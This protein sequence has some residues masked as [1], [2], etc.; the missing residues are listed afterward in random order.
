MSAAAAS[1]SRS[2]PNASSSIRACRAVST[3]I[4]GERHSERAGQFKASPRRVEARTERR[5][6]VYRLE[7]ELGGVRPPL[8]EGD[9]TARGG[10]RAPR[11]A[12][13]LARPRSPRAR[14]PRRDSAIEVTLEQPRL[15]EL[16]E[17][18]RSERDSSNRARRAGASRAPRRRRARHEQRGA[19]HVPAGPRA[20]PRGRR[21]TAPL[22]RSGPGARESPPAEPREGCSASAGLP[23]LSSRTASSSSAS[24]ASIRPLAA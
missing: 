5:E 4:S 1:A 14:R 2:A 12:R 22:H 23:R 17:Q 18:G 7:Q 13:D 16:R 10:R 3:A 9:A 24:A 21:A 15:D 6:A 8:G 11:R 19:R 20:L